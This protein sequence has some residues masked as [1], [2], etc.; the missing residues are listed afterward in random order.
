[1]IRQRAKQE[2]P[3]RLVAPV[4][5]EKPMPKLNCKVSEVMVKNLPPGKNP[6]I[7]PPGGKM[8]SESRAINFHPP[9]PRISEAKNKGEKKL[10][11][12]KLKK[13]GATSPNLSRANEVCSTDNLALKRPVK[14]A[15]LEIPRDVKEAQLQK[16]MSIQAEAQRAAV[17]LAT[18][19]FASSEPHVKRVKN[20]AQVELENLQKIKLNEKVTLENKDQPRSPKGTKPLYKVQIILPPETGSKVAKTSD[21]EDTPVTSRKQLT[22]KAKRDATQVP[23]P[24]EEANVPNGSPRPCQTTAQRRLRL[25]QMK[26]Q[27]EEH[28]IA[29]PLKA[30]APNTEEAKQKIL[31]QRTQ[32]T[33]TDASRLVENL[34][35][36]HR[37][38][39]AGQNAA[40]GNTLERK[41]S[42]RR[43][44][45][46]DII[47]VDEE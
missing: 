34:A 22:P 42:T 25:R 15:P 47:Q 17:K 41:Q 27:Q 10:R 39:G 4:V 45:V 43:M 31:G 23:D 16:I 32:K 7:I 3:G 9:S 46:G 13:E 20:L 14:L 30:M 1:M 36:K 37:E 19:G 38:R 35:K 18:T 40:G 12:E 21:A 8:G 11:A 33:L 2:L 24:H 28:S 6:I 26:E 5:E 29:K 44:A